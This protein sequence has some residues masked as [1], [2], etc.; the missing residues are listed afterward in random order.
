MIKGAVS[1]TSFLVVFVLVY[2]YYSNHVK[3]GKPFNIRKIPGLDAITEAI[4]RCT[5]MGRPVHYTFG[6]DV[7]GANHLASFE[8]LSYTAAMCAR[9]G[10]DIIATTAKPEITP[11]VEEI[12]RAAFVKEGKADAFKPDNVRFMSSEQTA[13]IQG[14][15]GIFMRERPAANL[16][17]GAFHAE[18]LQLSEVGQQIGAIQIGGTGRTIQIPFFVATCDYVLI[19]DELF[20]AGA[21]I[22]RQPSQVGALFAQDFGKWMSIALIIIGSLFTTMGN[23]TLT[24]LMKK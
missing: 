4:G 2:Y 16:M 6:T 15:H 23:K 17:L 22:G 19:G 21:Y 12:I 7:F 14:I 18:S 8:V 24:D 1:F 9:V 3:N 20:A 5:E 11:I 10:T 13:Y